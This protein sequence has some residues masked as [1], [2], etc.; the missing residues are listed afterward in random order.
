MMRSK[1]LFLIG[2]VA[3]LGVA[4]ACS[5]GSN[6]VS[7]GATS[8]VAGAAT[9]TAASSTTSTSAARTTT[10]TGRSTTTRASTSTTAATSG[11]G[12]NGCPVGSWVAD[13]DEINS[14][15]SQ[16]QL[17]GVTISAHG[18]VLWELNP[19]K[20][21]ALRSDGYGIQ[22]TGPANATV[23]LTGQETGTYTFDATTLTP[24][25]VDNQFHVNATVGGVSIPGDQ[26][27]D[28]LLRAFPSS[29]V[30]YQCTGGN[31]VLMVNTGGRTIPQTWKPVSGS[32]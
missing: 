14:F 28:A 4:A 25:L 23:D 29:A 19:D 8:T 13:T 31:L 26:F 5:G 12:A 18:R 7:S 16:L 27:A 3:V 21:F 22:L 32:S 20:T 15:F 11:G 2:V 9:T 30:P 24:T 1:V 17:P 10:T 6:D